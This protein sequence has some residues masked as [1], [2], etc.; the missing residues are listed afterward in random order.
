MGDT[1]EEA[2]D[3]LFLYLRNNL[4]L[5]CNFNSS[6]FVNRQS[7]LSQKEDGARWGHVIP[8]YLYLFLKNFLVEYSCFPMLR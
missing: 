5:I 6:P 8:L 1:G 2:R 3:D 7:H 4:L